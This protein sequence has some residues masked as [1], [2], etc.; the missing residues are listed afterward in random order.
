MED[1]FRGFSSFRPRFL[2][3]YHRA[4]FLTFRCFSTY[5]ASRLC[6]IIHVMLISGP[7]LH[8]ASGPTAAHR[9]ILHFDL[10]CFYAQVEMIRNPALRKVPLGELTHH[11]RL[12]MAAEQMLSPRCV[13]FESP[14]SSW[15]NPVCHII[16]YPAEIHNSHL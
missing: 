15:L 3:G 12:F 9:V 14:E 7:S 16:R 10:D 4:F 2:H 6:L 1:Q 13:S 5:R 8:K 11:C